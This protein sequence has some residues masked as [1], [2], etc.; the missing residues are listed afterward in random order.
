MANDRAMRASRDG[1]R[2][3]GSEWEGKGLHRDWGNEAL[4]GG[5]ETGEESTV[6]V[7][8]VLQGELWSCA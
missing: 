5:Q 1:A 3:S 7:L 8:A 4:M 6:V 2:Q